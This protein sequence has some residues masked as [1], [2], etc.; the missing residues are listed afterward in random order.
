LQRAFER[1]KKCCMG[2]PGFISNPMG[3][4]G[5][6]GR[7]Q[8]TWGARRARGEAVTCGAQT[9]H[10]PC[11]GPPV[12]GSQRCRHHGGKGSG[13]GYL[14]VPKSLRV[15]RNQ[16]LHGLRA[17]AKV[18]LAKQLAERRVP[19]RDLDVAFRP[20]ATKIY[21]PNEEL[22]KIVLLQRLAGEV[23]Q[24]EVDAAVEQAMNS[25][26]R[27]QVLPPTRAERR[28]AK[29]QM[30]CEDVS[31]AVPEDTPPIRKRLPGGW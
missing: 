6:Q 25:Y 26:R 9:K 15:S 3:L 12:R 11:L 28:A 19:P 23:S 7:M 22:L 4:G 2:E 14:S 16:V 8:Q 5:F 27:D 31:D 10:G 24:A 21:G 17:A 1:A 18:E 13:R 20:Y 29:S 30:I